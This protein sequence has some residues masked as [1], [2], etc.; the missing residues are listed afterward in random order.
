MTKRKAAFVQSD[1]DL[2]VTSLGNNH[3][4]SLQLLV[5]CVNYNA[6][7]STSTV[8]VRETCKWRTTGRPLPRARPA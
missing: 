6:N 1:S 4:I 2:L 3:W 5:G 8:L 7:R